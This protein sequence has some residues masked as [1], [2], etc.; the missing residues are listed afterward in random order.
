MKIRVTSPVWLWLE[1]GGLFQ[2]A[3]GD[4]QGYG[5]GGLELRRAYDAAKMRKDGSCVVDLSDEAAHVL[6]ELA[7]FMACAAGDDAAQ[8]PPDNASALGE[9]NAARALM[10][11]IER[12]RAGG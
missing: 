10:R 7:D 3:P 8:P 6:W 1:G 2:A 11:Q 12:V 5:P 9:L 4:D